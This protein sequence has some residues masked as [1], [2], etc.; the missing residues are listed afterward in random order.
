MLSIRTRRFTLFSRTTREGS[1]LLPC[2]WLT[3]RPSRVVLL[4]SCRLQLRV[5]AARPQKFGGLP[6]VLRP[7]LDLY[8]RA[9]DDL[10]DKR[11]RQRLGCTP[12]Q[13]H[14]EPCTRA[15]ARRPSSSASSLSSWSRV[16]PCRARARPARRGLAGARESRRQGARLPHRH[17]LGRGPDSASLWK[18]F[19]ARGVP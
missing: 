19:R 14:L 10:P 2:C 11:G 17:G 8:A 16:P 5:G 6:A 4:G 3:Y 1:A 12:A 15:R 9:Q 13:R 7:P 18:N